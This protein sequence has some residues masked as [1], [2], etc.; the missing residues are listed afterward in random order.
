MKKLLMTF[1]LLASFCGFSATTYTFTEGD[2]N[3]NYTLSSGQATLTGV[4]AT[5]G[6]LPAALTLPSVVSKSEIEYPVVA[7]GASCF[8]EIAIT[9]LKVADSIK[10]IGS[11][12]FY[13]CTA[14][15]SVDLG[16][17]LTT[18]YGNDNTTSND[19][20][21]YVQYGAFGN[22]INLETVTFG[23]NLITIG[24]HAFSECWVLESVN[25]PDSVKT[26]GPNAFYNNKA[27]LL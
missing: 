5:S 13:N 1:A 6:A 16:N 2:L 12:A 17:G 26:I 25:L 24:G 18:I 21:N 11:G 9:S 20:D 4:S 7:V 19:P 23:S 3:W 27:C 15:T 10:T 14:L 22:C 8:Q